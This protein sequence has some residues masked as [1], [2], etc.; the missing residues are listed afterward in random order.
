M[1]WWNLKKSNLEREREIEGE[2]EG[3]RF[4]HSIS[5]TS[6]YNPSIYT[7]INEHKDYYTKW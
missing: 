7:Y 2:I 6:G 3:Y 5:C 4:N 1:I